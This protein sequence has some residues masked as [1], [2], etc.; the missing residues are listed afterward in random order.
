MNFPCPTAIHCSDYPFANLSSEGGERCLDCPPVRGRYWTS[1]GY[2]C[3]GTLKL[4]YSTEGQTAANEALNR[5]LATACPNCNPERVFCAD[6]TC[7]DGSNLS[8]ICVPTSQ[9]DADTLA[10]A[11]AA[12]ML[13]FCD[14][15]ESLFQATCACPDGTSSHTVYSSVSKAVAEAEC[16]VIPKTC[17]VCNT[18]QSCDFALSSTSGVHWC[19]PA[20]TV[21][22]FTLE[23]ANAM[24]HSLACVYAAFGGAL[25]SVPSFACVSNSFTQKIY[26]T[27][28]VGP[29]FSWGI[30]GGALPAGLTLSQL[31][32]NIGQISGTP[33][34]PGIYTFTV[35][36]MLTS[37]SYIHRTYT[38]TIFGFTTDPTLP[39]G[40]VGEEYSQQI[41]ADGGSGNYSFTLTFGSLPGGLELGSTGFI[42]GTPTTEETALFTVM[43]QDLVTPAITCEMEFQIDIQAAADP[44]DTFTVITSAK[45]HYVIGLNNVYVWGDARSVGTTDVTGIVFYKEGSTII[46]N[47]NCGLYGIADPTNLGILA[48]SKIVHGVLTGTGGYHTSDSGNMEVF[49]VGYWPN[50]VSI[51][52]ISLAA[53]QTLAPGLTGL[54]TI[55]VLG[56]FIYRN[57]STL[58][59]LRAGS[60]L[61]FQWGGG[62]AVYKRHDNSL[63]PT[64]LFHFYQGTASPVSAVTI[65]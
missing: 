24:A 46:G 44:F 48:A 8:T 42:T 35:A 28:I 33:T 64:G 30:S 2:C 34:T 54:L 58:L 31:S 19:V 20:G 57:V 37:C 50:T 53:F 22:W 56:D 51:D 41:V 32:N 5:T 65:T 29:P 10:A 52:G 9:E 17:Y 4:A 26:L 14:E 61:I 40:T 63:V 55:D 59:T 43:V 15:K 25:S 62:F 12:A 1:Q 60:T 13:P 18:E 36:V 6:A 16:A 11:A 7:T 23:E 21:C 39:D 38:M 45:S 3:D 49:G 27:G 47:G